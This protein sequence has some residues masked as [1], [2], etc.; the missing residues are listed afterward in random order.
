MIRMLMLISLIGL[1]AGNASAELTIWANNGED[2]VVQDR[3]RRVAWGDDFDETNS[4]WDGQRINLFGAR[5]EVVNFNLILESI[6]AATTGVNVAFDTLEYPG[7]PG[8]GVPAFT[9]AGPPAELND[10]VHPY[11][12]GLFNHVGR[13][14]ELF[15]I[16][17]L[18]IRGLSNM[19]SNAHYDERV[20]PR[21]FQRPHVNGVPIDSAS[22]YYDRPD[23]DTFYPDIAVPLELHPGFGIAANQ[24]QSVWCDIYIPK[25]ASAGIYTGTL[26]V[27]CVHGGETIEEY[28]PVRL[29][30]RDF[31]LPDLPHGK[32]MLAGGRRNGQMMERY[33]GRRGVYPGQPEYP[34]AALI[35]ARHAQM[36]HRHKITLLNSDATPATMDPVAVDQLTGDLFTAERG[37]DG[38]GTGTGD[39]L[40]CIG[41]YSR[42]WGSWFG[43]SDPGTLSDTEQ[44]A[45]IWQHS[46]D[47]VNW[48]DA[49]APHTPTDYF[50]FLIDESSDHALIEKW[51]GMLDANPGPGQ[52][53]KSFATV[54]MSAK[55]AIPSL[56]VF[57]LTGR[58]L[59]PYDPNKPSIPDEPWWG[60]NAVSLIDDPHKDL[61]LYNGNHRIS[62]SFCIDED[63]VALRVKAWSQFKH[64]ISRWFYW[65]STYYTNYNLYGNSCPASDVFTRAQTFGRND[66][67]HS[68]TLGETGNHYDN[69]N[70]VLFYPGID[71]LHDGQGNFAL[72]ANNYNIQGP[73]ASLRLKYWRRGIQDIDY[74]TMA[75]A[76]DPDAVEGI[77]N[78]GAGQTGVLPKTLWEYGCGDRCGVGYAHFG[79]SWSDDPDV[80]EAA[81]LQLADIIENSGI[82]PG[83]I[84]GN[85]SVELS[86][87]VTA[88]QV[89]AGSQPANVRLA[90]DTNEDGRIGMAD[91]IY[92]IQAVSGL[93]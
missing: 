16:R 24:N 36:A 58:M 74:L 27:N 6:G 53:L 33:I 79:K 45:R 61:Q 87:A 50:L 85:G 25:T 48:F 23:A 15:Y 40:Y 84:D 86:D 5:N 41:I 4:V 63:G 76:V 77:I 11:G 80:W 56:D 89:L 30:V 93:R 31:A 3:I 14:I 64:R 35:T 2:K 29:V 39:N 90:A 71:Y 9:I 49:L 47:W 54:T 52:R 38:P 32:T 69:G 28:V 44:R 88:L 68:P 10:G 91:A 70:G 22:T 82:T 34:T 73:I 67:E 65:Q 18:Q 37:Y 26:S 72:S 12:H 1:F 59:D 17:Y 43:T 62:G 57:S 81:R 19:V 75:A 42:W 21:R 66:G 55:D 46:N 13:N 78:G 83:D 8:A 20:Y 60:P 7:N 92:V 51:A